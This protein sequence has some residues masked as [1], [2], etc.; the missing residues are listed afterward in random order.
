MRNCGCL[1][2]PS[3]AYIAFDGPTLYS[4]DLLHRRLGILLNRPQLSSVTSREGSRYKA[5]I[6]SEVPEPRV[7]EVL[8]H[9]SRLP[10]SIA[11][12]VTAK[13]TPPEAFA[14]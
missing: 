14:L 4:G 7:F 12:Q 3:V 6:R 8:P 10:Q 2:V 13:Q 9:V 5:Q 1:T 11:G